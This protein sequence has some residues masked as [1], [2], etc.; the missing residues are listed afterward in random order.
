MRLYRIEFE[1]V[2]VPK[3]GEAWVLA[4]NRAHALRLLTKKDREEHQKEEHW[5]P[6][7]DPDGERPLTVDDFVEVSLDEAKVV[8]FDDGDY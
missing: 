2:S 7:R 6:L 3:N 4:A 5:P 8:H 1:G